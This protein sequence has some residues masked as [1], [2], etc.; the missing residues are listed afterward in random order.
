MY[1]YNKDEG[2]G[3]AVD[4]DGNVYI[5]GI[6][7]ST[8][9]TFPVTVGPDLTHNGGVVDAFVAKVDKTGTA[10]LYAGFL[11]G[12]A[13]DFGN[14][15]AVD[16]AGNAY[17]TGDTESTQSTFPV[18]GLGPSLVHSGSADAFVCKLNPL[19]TG[20]VYCGYIGGAGSDTGAGIAL[21]P[22]CAGPCEVWV[23][24]LT[25]ST[26]GMGFPLLVGPD[27][28]YNG[29]AADV[30]INKL[31]ASGGRVYSGY[32]GGSAD[33]RAR[34]VAVDAA[35]NAYVAGDTQSSE[36]TFPVSTGWTDPKLKTFSGQTDAF[37]AKVNPGGTGLLY[38]GYI[39]GPFHDHGH[40][41]A[42]NSAGSAYIAGSTENS[43][44]TFPVKAGP[45]VTFNGNFDAFV[46]KINPTGTALIYA[47]YIGGS[48]LDSGHG[49]A[50]DTAGN[51]YVAGLTSSTEATFPVKVG[52]DATYNGGSQDAFVAKIAAKIVLP[53]PIL[54]AGAGSVA[55]DGGSAHF[56]FNVQQRTTGDPIRGELR[57]HN[58][59]TG[60]E[61]HSVEI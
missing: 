42:V 51:A 29:G 11:G 35:G 45:D 3:I 15:I 20:W 31:N 59:A 16:G 4:G 27:L 36:V 37:V 28:T 39:G 40:S 5:V 47:G 13:G 49:I 32:I 24:G 12:S 17:V 57:Y 21:K 18:T 10:L 53:F 1:G 41:V 6:T 55:A 30:F 44:A 60:L 38:A 54:V 8:E 25:S 14:G 9:P 34:S 43:Q 61:V 19:G 56:D 33:D 23:T 7:T 22:G 52:P 58:L 50:V 46:V 48:G 2:H 26:Q